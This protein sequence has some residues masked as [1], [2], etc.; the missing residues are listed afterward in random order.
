MRAAERTLRQWL[1]V[2]IGLTSFDISSAHVVD[3]PSTKP[4]FPDAARITNCLSRS[5]ADLID[6]RSRRHQLLLCRN[7][8]EGRNAPAGS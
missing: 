4:S 5:S 7:A 2:W 3:L 6:Y 8:I 1:P